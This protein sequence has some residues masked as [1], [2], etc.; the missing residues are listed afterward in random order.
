VL[1]PFNEWAFS[2]VPFIK[3]WKTNSK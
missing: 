3:N 1:C 2:P